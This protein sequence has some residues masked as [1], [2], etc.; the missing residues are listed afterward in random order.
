MFACFR[1]GG[2]GIGDWGLVIGERGRGGQGDGVRGRW[3]EVNS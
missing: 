3:G 1:D 2:L